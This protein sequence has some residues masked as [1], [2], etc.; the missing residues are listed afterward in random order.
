M[1]SMGIID[2]PGPGRRVLDYHRDYIAIA[3]VHA[4]DGEVERAYRRGDL[5]AARG[6]LFAHPGLN[7]RPQ[8]RMMQGRRPRV[9]S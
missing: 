4:I 7:P 3:L 8:V 2:I 9:T 6:R 1:L 5:F